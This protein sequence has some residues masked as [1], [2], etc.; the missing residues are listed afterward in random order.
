MRFANP[1]DR[2]R[3]ARLSIDLPKSIYASLEHIIEGPPTGIQKLPATLST[4]EVP[5]AVKFAA[6]APGWAV[7][8]PSIAVWKSE[9]WCCVRLWE[10]WDGGKKAPQAAPQEQAAPAPAPSK[11]AVRAP[12]EESEPAL[13]AC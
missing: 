13:R 1:A 11:A 4:I 8:N 7:L 9:L 5:E 12:A 10:G 3:A 2:R 6:G